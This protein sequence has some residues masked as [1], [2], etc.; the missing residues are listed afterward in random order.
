[1]GKQAD[2]EVMCKTCEKIYD[3]GVVSPTQ[4]TGCAAS[5][6]SGPGDQVKILGHYG[7]KHDLTLFKFLRSP[8]TFGVDPVCDECIDR[9]VADGR[10]EVEQEDV[11]TAEEQVMLKGDVFMG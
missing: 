6:V 11:S 5:V 7:S 2:N 1:M 9:F 3:Q 8:L 4:A 10:I